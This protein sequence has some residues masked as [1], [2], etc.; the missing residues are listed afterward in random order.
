[1]LISSS[2]TFLLGV[3][4]FIFQVDLHEISSRT[5]HQ[6]TKLVWELLKELKSQD[7]IPWVVMGDLNEIIFHNEKW[8]GKDH[9][10]KQIARF[11][12]ALDHY[13]LNAIWN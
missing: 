13:S 1:M 12:E 6:Q 8:G 11:S 3:G 5:G 7:N 2:G 4:G 9:N 10:E